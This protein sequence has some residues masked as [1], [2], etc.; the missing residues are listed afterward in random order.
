MEKTE[1]NGKKTILQ[2][3]KF[4]LV[5]VSNTL[6]SLIITN[7]LSL[8][9]GHTDIGWVQATYVI[10][11]YICGIFNSLFLNTRWTFKKEY[12][13]TKAEIIKFILVNAITCTLNVLMTRLFS[14]HVFYAESSVTSWLCGLMNITESAG[15]EKIVTLLSTVLAAGI[16]MIVNFTCTKLFVFNVKDKDITEE[17]DKGNEET[18]KEEH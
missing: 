11:G 4:A 3:I 12:K 10:I 7:L 18:E 6:V 8:V 5:G 2:F 13:R 9:F 15:A 16:G 1:N 17:A 14:R